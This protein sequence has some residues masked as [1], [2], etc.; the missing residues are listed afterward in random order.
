M[1]D[2]RLRKG[3]C[4]TIG[5]T[6]KHLHKTMTLTQPIQ[7]SAANSLHAP[8]LLTCQPTVAV[9]CCGCMVPLGIAQ[10]QKADSNG[11]G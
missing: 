11:L 2:Y 3:C 7:H 6:D 10:R 5:W 1:L 4:A 8:G 9:Q